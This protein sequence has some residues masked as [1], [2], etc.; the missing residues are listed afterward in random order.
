MINMAFDNDIF[1]SYAH[2]DN[3]PLVRDDEGWVSQF[4]RALEVR[5]DQLLGKKSSVWRD[6][7]L[8]GNDYYDDTIVAQLPNA[9]VLVSVFTPRY[10]HSNSCT[11]EL[12]HFCETSEKVGGLRVQDKTRIFKVLKTPVP[13][14]LHPE[15][16]RECLGYE[17]FK[18]DPVTWRVRE[19]NQVFGGDAEREFWIKLDD[20]AQDLCQLL[21]WLERGPSG[22]DEADAIEKNRTVFLADCSYDVREQY[23]IVK[24]DLLGH[25]YR[26][27]PDRPLPLNA[28]DLLPILRDML[29]Q[30]S[31][32]VHLVG[33]SYGIVP[34]GTDRSIVELQTEL[35]IEREEHGDF[36]RL[37]WMQPGIETD[38]ERQKKLIDFL[39]I[40][41]RTHKG[42]DL[43]ET[44][45][46]DLN[47]QIHRYLASTN[48]DEADSHEPLD[49]IEV[50]RV[51]LVCDPRDSRNVT[52]VADYLFEQGYEVMLPAFQGDEADVRA[53]HEENLR[54][55]DGL[56]IYYGAANELW[57]RSKL[58]EQRKRAGLG[59]SNPLKAIAILVAPPN[60]ARDNWFRTREAR[61]IHQEGD[62]TVDLVD[63]FLADLQV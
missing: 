27:L 47:T 52:P 11:K 55:A 20:V 33:R 28:E 32:S 49:A 45:L 3:Q 62:F 43:L 29:H 14:D 54:N 34:E 12:L 42:A 17:F 22:L 24:R 26:V 6:P 15:P 30:S 56:L 39:R 19:L 57:L 13:V 9:A 1:I 8:Q 40:D 4:H 23:E 21:R 60:S 44:P 5:I 16:V 35:A 48:T 10:V 37:V 2:L 7:K 36:A 41:P 46:Q 50:R 31:L 25:N 63:S 53:D 18:V 58:R 51:Y 59:G 61:V 38:D